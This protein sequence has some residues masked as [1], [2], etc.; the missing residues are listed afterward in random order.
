MS[1]EN[2]SSLNTGIGAPKIKTKSNISL[3]KHVNE[4]FRISKKSDS[5]ACMISCKL[6]MYVEKQLFYAANVMQAFKITE[7]L[8]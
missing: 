2:H 4:W 1:G 7:Q 3:I 5:F 8:N 6:Y